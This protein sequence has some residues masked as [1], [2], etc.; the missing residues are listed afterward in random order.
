MPRDDPKTSRP[1]A[2]HG[3]PERRKNLRLRAVL[4]AV[5][6]SLADNRRDL[7]LQFKRIA[8][9]QAEID[10]LKQRRERS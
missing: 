2:W 9:I 10:R 6:E 5:K 1:S 7:D 4:D 3:A 8:Q